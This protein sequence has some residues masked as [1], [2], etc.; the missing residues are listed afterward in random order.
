MCGGTQR[1][2]ESPAVEPGLSPRVRGNPLFEQDARLAERSI[3]ACAGEPSFGVRSWIIA[4]VY[5][6]VCGGTGSIRLRTPDEIGLSPRVRGN[7][8]RRADCHSHPGSIPACAGEPHQAHDP[9]NQ[10]WVYP[11]VCGG[12]CLVSSSTPMKRGLSP[13]VRGNLLS[14]LQH[15][16]EK[17]SIP[18]C[19]GE[20]TTVQNAAQTEKVYPRVC[21]GT[22]KLNDT[23]RREYGLSPRV[24]G[25]HLTARIR[26]VA[27]RSIP[28]CAGEPCSCKARCLCVRVYPRVCGG[29]DMS[30]KKSAICQGLS[31]RVRG[32]RKAERYS[33][34]GIRS[35]PACAGEPEWR[36]F[37]K[38]RDSVYPRVCGGTAWWT[39]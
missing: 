18:A 39:A 2:L 23:R 26:S 29:T 5:P 16:H 7:R 20:P 14:Q 3:P 21:G 4:P 11:R 38:M 28:A 24:R 32:N 37:A 17:R 34:Q 30:W 25:N 6:R 1:A 36:V 31:P 22:E 9:P 8:T 33:P 19:A 35:I 10:R 12:T 15:T 13:R 27:V